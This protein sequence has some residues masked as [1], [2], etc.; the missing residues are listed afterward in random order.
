MPE[1]FGVNCRFADSNLNKDTCNRLAS[2][3]ISIIFDV[4]PFSMLINFSIESCFRLGGK[5]VNNMN[6]IN[7][8][9]QRRATTFAWSRRSVLL[10]RGKC[11]CHLH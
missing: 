10:L 8:D 6:I 3:Y 5:N 7:S 2:C 11:S 1:T 4:S 9:I